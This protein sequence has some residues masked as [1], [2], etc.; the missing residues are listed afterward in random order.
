[1]SVLFTCIPCQIPDAETVA[2]EWWDKVFIPELASTLMSEES[3]VGR[4]FARF[5]Y[6]LLQGFDINLPPLSSVLERASFL[7]L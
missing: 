3:V 2:V 7:F 1:M 4:I 5:Q 6:E